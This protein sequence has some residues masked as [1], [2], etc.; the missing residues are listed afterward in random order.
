MPDASVPG[1]FNALTKSNRVKKVS[2]VYM[3]QWIIRGKSRNIQG[4]QVS[5]LVAAS[6]LDI[7]S[8]LRNSFL[9]AKSLSAGHQT[10]R[11]N[12]FN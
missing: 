6:G 5:G 2:F 9:T 12:I 4:G 10:S 3:T 11:S 8:S 7:H 1:A